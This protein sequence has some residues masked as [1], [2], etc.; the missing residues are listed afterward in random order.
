M[1][2]KTETKK[3][4]KVKEGHSDKKLA[5]ICVRGNVDTPQTVIDTLHMLNL[6]RKNHA[7][8]VPDTSAFRGMIDKVKDMVTW[9]EI[10]NETFEEMLKARGEAYQGRTTDSKQKY[11]YRVLEVKGKKYK[12]YFRLNPPRKG[13]GRKGIKVA[14]QA[15]GALGYRGN[16]IN[17]LI[18]RML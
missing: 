4:T 13:F 14:F 11:S 17:D 9:G 5:V 18:K 7:S 16:K 8:V 15:H 12:N 1:T 6:R 2:T 10:D 3:E